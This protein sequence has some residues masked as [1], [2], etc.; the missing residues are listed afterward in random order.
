[1]ARGGARERGRIGRL[2]QHRAGAQRRARL[3]HADRRGCEPGQREQLGGG[4]LQRR[5]ARGGPGEERRGIAVAGDAPVLER[6]HAVDRR[7]AALEAVLG[8]H[9]RRLPLLVEPAQQPDQLVAG[10]GVQLRGRL[11]E[12]HQPRPAGERR[13]ERDALLLAAGELVRRAIQQRVDAERERDLLDAARDRG[14]AVAAALERER[15][16]GAHRAHHQLRLG[17][18][19]EHAGERAEARRPVLAGVE[20]GERDATGEMPAVEVRHEAAGGPQQRRLAVAGE[21]REQAELAR[22]DLDADVLERRRGDAGVGVADLLEAQQRRAHRSIPRRS[23]NGSS[24]ASASPRQSAA[25][26]AVGAPVDFRI[27]GEAR[28]AR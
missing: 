8:E 14:G 23:A 21:A 11:V 19:E 9:D 27:G 5:R 20:A 3:A 28:G 13:A 10:N 2:G 15:E 7:Q 6:D 4:R 1:M 25:V 22:L 18:L 26:P 16:L 12:Q 17:V 24:T